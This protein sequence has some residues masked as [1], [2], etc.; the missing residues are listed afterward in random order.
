MKE[1]QE[2]NRSNQRME[3]ADAT[4]TLMNELNK[5]SFNEGN[6]PSNTYGVIPEDVS[7]L[8]LNG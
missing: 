4:M 3:P 1:M 2:D 7:E 8:Q 6:H 5:M